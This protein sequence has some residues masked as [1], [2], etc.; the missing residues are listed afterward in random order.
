[1]NKVIFG[2]LSLACSISACSSGKQA[3]SN[4]NSTSNQTKSEQLITQLKKLNGQ[5]LVGHQD[6]TAYGVN[7]TWSDSVK[8]CDIRDVCGDY[9]AI[10]GW[11]IG[12][13][14]LDHS[15]NLDSVDFKLMKQLIQE[16]HRRGGVI[17]I[18]WHHDNPFSG[19]TAWD[20]TAAVASLLQGKSHYDKYAGWVDK[21]A[22]FLKDL[23]DEKGEPI[24]VFFRPCHEMS[25]GWFWWGKGHC[26]PE[27][28]KQLWRQTVGILRNKH[29][30]DNL[31]MVYSTDQVRDSAEF[32]TWYPG[33]KWV[34]VLGL[35][36]YD[37]SGSVSGY[38]E[39]LHAALEMLGEVARKHNKIFALT[40]TGYETIPEPT[41][42][43]TRLLPALRGTGVSWVLLW[44]NDRPSHHYA[45]MPGHSSSPDFV[46]FYRAPET[47][48]EKDWV[49]INR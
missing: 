9:P 29:H 31:L 34:D 28:Y 16:A 48:F 25:G 7:W 42:Y 39:P 17:T 8:K 3:N 6:A 47:L 14:E 36:Y 10:Y 45:P 27:E 11:D 32:L 43:T 35:D 30:L 4:Q 2:L 40:E 49:S 26:T 41:W 19:G 22:A 1:M 23:Q 18:T 15:C 37:R 44:R 21:A 12:H 20:T 33:D 38:T 5:F 46:N 24:P 13:I